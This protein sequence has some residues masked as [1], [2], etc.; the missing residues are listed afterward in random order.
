MQLSD[1]DYDLP[2]EAIAQSAL[3]PRDSSRLLVCNPDGSFVDSRVRDLPKFLAKG[4]LLVGNRTRVMNARV[5]AR[6]ETGAKCE[7][8]FLHP[9][10]PAC[11]GDWWVALARPSR[12][13]G[14]GELLTVKI[15]GQEGK[16]DGVAIEVGKAAGMGRRFARG[17]GVHTDQVL[18]D[19]GQVPLPLYFS[20]RLDSP[21]RY[22]TVFADAVGSA[23]APTAGLHFT[24]RLI[25]ALAR[26]GVGFTSVSLDIGVDTFRPV[27]EANPLEHPMHEEAY[28]IDDQAA[29]QVRLAKSSG[30][31]VVAVGTTSARAIE[32]AAVRN[33]EGRPTGELTPGSARTSILI[34]PG[35][36]F[37]IDGL[38][39][40]FHAPRSTLLM[41]LAGIYPDWRRAYDRAL[42]RGYRFL[43]FGDAMLIRPADSATEGTVA[44]I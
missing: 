14:P 36:K 44:A 40:N 18:R 21:D 29:E 43:S 30:N 6:R 5:L 3:E 8:L 17:V 32:A 10:D 38:L 2:K 12:R 13:I 11:P 41:L 19:H 27:T 26:S 31:A 33:D 35:H 15:P 25:D 7:L 9:C 39:T 16:T 23:A 4:D 42:D 22:Q 20:G 24:G 1:I 34:A 37:L 28:S